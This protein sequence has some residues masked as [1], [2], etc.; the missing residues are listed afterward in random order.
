MENVG[1]WYHQRSPSPGTRVY[2]SLNFSVRLS[3]KNPDNDE[4]VMNDIIRRSELHSIAYIVLAIKPEP[5]VRTPKMDLYGHWTSLC[6]LFLHVT[7]L[8][9]SLFSEFHYSLSLELTY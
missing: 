4:S 1:A 6:V 7:T 9:K 5:H 2:H 8:R 3:G